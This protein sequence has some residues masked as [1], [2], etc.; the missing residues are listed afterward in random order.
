MRVLFLCH[1]PPNPTTNGG[2][3]RL[4]YHLQALSRVHDTT[5]AFVADE[6]AHAES[7]RLPEGC[8]HVVRLTASGRRISHNR[9]G[10][11]PTRR[12]LDLLRSPRPAYVQEWRGADLIA[13]IRAL[14][15]LGP[16]DGTWIARP[17]L[18]SAARSAGVRADVVDVDDIQSEAF[19][20]RLALLGPY[21]SRLIDRAELM[22]MRADQWSLTRRYP[23]VAVCKEE[24]RQFFADPSRCHVLPNG[25]QIPS[26]S[27][28]RPCPTV[29][30]LFLGN[31][32]FFPNIDAVSW[33]ITAI[34]PLVRAARPETT[35]C[36]AGRSAGAFADRLAAVGGCTIVADPPAV[37]PVYQQARVVVVPMRLG[38]G[39]RIKSIEALAFARPLVSTSTGAEGIGLENGLHARVAD[40]PAAFAAAC[41]ELVSKPSEADLMGTRGRAY[42][43]RDFSWDTCAARAVSLLEAAVN[44]RLEKAS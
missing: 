20:R 15:R 42:V 29:D 7:C 9:V 13:Q 14:R 1:L 16:Y 5:L 22:K 30:L 19:A 17:Y 34:L 33:F 37:D 27:S 41:V 25:S 28:I 6:S 12:L 36:L 31:M 40:D 26:E 35:F 2:T 43:E 11:P 44:R 4:Y 21:R 3:Q 38:S 24:D 10:L 32:S 18:A 8:R 39:T 23:A